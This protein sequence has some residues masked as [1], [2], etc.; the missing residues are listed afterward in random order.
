MDPSRVEFDLVREEEK[1]WPGWALRPVDVTEEYLVRRKREWAL[2]DRVMVNSEFC[3]R[4]LVSQGV[5]EEKLVVV[6]LCYEPRAK[7]FGPV[8]DAGMANGQSPMANAYFE[9]ERQKNNRPFR[10]LFL[11]QVILRKG[12]QYLVEAAKLLREE[13]VIFDV[14]G[15]IGISDAA[16]KCAPSNVV[17]HGRVMRE[18]ASEWYRRANLFVLPTLSDGFAITQL[19]A[20]AQGLPVIV[21]PNC[22]AVVTHGEDGFIVPIRNSAAVAGAIRNYSRNPG[23]LAAHSAAAVKKAARFSLESLSQKLQEFERATVNPASL[24]NNPHQRLSA[25]ISVPGSV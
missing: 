1:R 10:V 12:I 16:V 8:T 15:P 23:M 17:F 9:R 7:K 18:N 13:D 14:V 3:R 20:M 11:G 19:E 25:K 4:A 22:G 6:P 2:A 5:P 24:D 21:T